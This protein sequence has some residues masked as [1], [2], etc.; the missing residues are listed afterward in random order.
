[1]KEKMQYNVVL[2]DN[3]KFVLASCPSL[4]FAENYLKEMY[5]IDKQ[6]AKHYNWSKIPKYKIIEI[7]KGEEA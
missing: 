1:M 5:K 2:E 7:I 6:L 3:Q 4:E